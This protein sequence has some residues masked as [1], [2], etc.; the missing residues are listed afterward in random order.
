MPSFLLEVQGSISGAAG[1]QAGVPSFLLEVRGN[2]SGAGRDPG[3]RAL[4]LAGGADRQ[5]TRDQLR[6][7]QGSR[8]RNGIG[9]EGQ[10]PGKGAAEWG[11]HT[12]DN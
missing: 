10:A 7:G 1:I 5:G 2:S 6:G 4:L 9:D 11:K 8:G 12:R 3:G